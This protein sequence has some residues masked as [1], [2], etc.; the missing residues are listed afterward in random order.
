MKEGQLNCAYTHCSI[1]VYEVSV[2][3]IAR[4]K[5]EFFE[6]ESRFSLIHVQSEAA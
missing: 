4:W 3:N 6:H 5:K 1:K 2:N